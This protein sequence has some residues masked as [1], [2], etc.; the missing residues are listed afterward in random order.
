[1]REL[2]E[3]VRDRYSAAFN[4]GL[5][6]GRVQPACPSTGS[7]CEKEKNK[8]CLKKRAWQSYTIVSYLKRGRGPTVVRNDGC[9][10]SIPEM[11]AQNPAV[12]LPCVRSFHDRR[13]GCSPDLAILIPEDTPELIIM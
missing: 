13:H 10:K 2:R 5:D 4:L 9:P 3:G 6:G 11:R 8:I 12:H 1:M 7:L